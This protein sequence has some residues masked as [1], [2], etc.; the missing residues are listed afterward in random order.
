MDLLG[1]FATALEP[2]NLLFCLLGVTLGTF[3]GILPGLGSS[4]GIAIMLPLT[5]GMEPLTALIML[6]GLYYGVEYG[7]TI[8]SVLLGV[9]GEGPTMVTVLEGHKMAL[10]GRAG[11]AL[12]ISAVGSFAAGTV[13]IVGLSM[14]APAFSSIA[15]EFGPP[16]M[17]ALMLLGL[18]TVGGLAGKSHAKGYA[19]AAVG[20]VLAMVGLDSTSGEAR[21]TFGLLEISFGIELV[22]I[23]LG[24]YAIAELVS[25][26]SEEQQR[27]PIR[28]RLREMVLSRSDLRKS[29]GAVT[30]GGVL[31]FIM[32]CL[33]GAGPTISTFFSYDIERRI[34]AQRGDSEF[35]RGDIRG[36]A[37]PEAANNSAVN[38][39]FVPTLALGI[40]GSGTTAILLGAFVA[41]GLQPGPQFL[42]EQADLASALIASFFIGNA[43]LLIQNLPLAPLFASFLRAPF[44]HVYPVVLAVAIVSAFAVNKRISDLW[45]AL[46]VGVFGYFVKRFDYPVAPLILGLVLGDMIEG[47]LIRSLAMGHGSPAIFLQRPITVTIFA[48]IIVLTVIGPMVRRLRARRL[49]TPIS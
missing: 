31:G 26:A 4:S 9:P 44:S 49:P 12:A 15:L 8:C 24:L 2:T 7:G 43:I 45:I 30:R 17:L 38:G 35:G 22:A 21:F 37:G 10:Q 34:A 29:S 11:Q 40:P 25:A 32:G 3:V 33:P 36:V 27:A 48:L 42:V 41:F 16:E 18:A 6:A 14:A 20:V 23:V 5:L 28:T 47:H 13:S 39:S 46:I 1:G 19:M